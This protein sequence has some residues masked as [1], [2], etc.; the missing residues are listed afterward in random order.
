MKIDDGGM[1]IG[2]GTG[3]NRIADVL[4]EIGENSIIKPVMMQGKGV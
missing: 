2:S 4:I 3:H 1:V